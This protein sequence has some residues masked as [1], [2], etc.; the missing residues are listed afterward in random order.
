MGHLESWWNTHVVPHGLGIKID[1]V[2]AAALLAEEVAMRFH[3]GTKPACGPIQI[4]LPDQTTLHQRVQAVVNRGHG[5]I[6]HGL[7]GP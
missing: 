2:D 6:G 5:N 4:H 1:V 3:V 7:L